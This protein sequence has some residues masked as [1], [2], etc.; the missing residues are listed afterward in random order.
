MDDSTNF[1]DIPAT[2]LPDAPPSFSNEP[3]PTVLAVHRLRHHGGQW[4]DLGDHLALP[5]RG[6]GN[7]PARG[8][9]LAESASS[10]GACFVS[11]GGRGPAEA[12]VEVMG[13][14][15]QPP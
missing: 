2:Y 15:A 9:H 1:P 10:G 14:Q 5:A 13:G 3:P 8:K 4:R 12:R 7:G 11:R 6:S